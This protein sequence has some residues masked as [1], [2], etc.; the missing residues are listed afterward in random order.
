[1][2]DYEKY[3][4]QSGLV[5][6]KVRLVDGGPNASALVELDDAPVDGIVTGD[7]VKALHPG[8]E[9]YAK[10]LGESDA[11]DLLVSVHAGAVEN[12]WIYAQMI[13]EPLT[14]TIQRTVKGGALGT[15]ECLKPLQAFV[16]SSQFAVSPAERG[17]HNEGM[18]GLQ[19]E[20]VLTKVNREAGDLVFSPAALVYSELK[21]ANENHTT[22][23]VDVIKTGDTRYLCVYKGVLVFLPKSL[24]ADVDGP[25]EDLQVRVIGYS[26]EK[27]QTRVVVSRRAALAADERKARKEQYKRSKREAKSAWDAWQKTA[28]ENELVQAT[29][30]GHTPGLGLFCQL[31]PGVVGL[32]PESRIP[33]HPAK[34][35][36]TIWVRIHRIHRDR[37]R[38][39][40]D[41]MVTR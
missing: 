23:S 22:I 36:S 30:N 7:E 12:A 9:V 11:G 18:V 38:I 39:S 34:V 40:L 16:P 4:L 6:G 41:A 33:G 8:D 26:K 24:A 3:Q 14:C 1:M 21:A 35:G 27:G 31:V 13:S 25:G 15:I 20:G 10:V 19:L 28:V 5:H 32:V 2:I 17:K 29:V 37:Q